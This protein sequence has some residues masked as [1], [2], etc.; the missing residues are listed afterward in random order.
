MNK[1][2]RL[3]PIYFLYLLAFAV[4]MYGQTRGAA[5]TPGAA[6]QGVAPGQRGPGAGQ[7]AGAPQGRGGAQLAYDFNDHEGWK[8]IFDGRTLNGWDGPTSVWRVEDGAIVGEST[9][10]HPTI[11]YV[12]ASNTGTAYLILKGKLKNFELKAE[13]NVAQ[14][15]NSGIQFRATRLGAIPDAAYAA[16]LEKRIPA[17]G[18]TVRPNNTAWENR[19]Y[20]MDL[21]YNI[22]TSL[23]DC[24]MGPQRGVGQLDF[25]NNP[26]PPRSGSTARRGTAV[27]AGAEGE[28]AELL[29]TLADSQDQT[30]YW[31]VGDWN[32]VQI[33]ANGNVLMASANGHLMDVW[34]DDNQKFSN[35]EGE[36]ALQLEGAGNVKVMFRNLWLKILP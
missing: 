3:L 34:I 5:P 16:Q 9:V 26:L 10:E 31:K 28:K 2:T 35:P 36:I 1:N 30:G 25:G 18:P 15:T 8:Q 21:G 14:G 29:G 23:I 11:W 32:Q 20:Q 19:G 6:Q 17:G 4:V 24:C 7:G 33:I 12:T 13:I 27:R 22:N